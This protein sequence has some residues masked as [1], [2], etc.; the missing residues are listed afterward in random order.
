MIDDFTRLGITATDDL[1]LI[2]K[3]FRLEYR[4]PPPVEH[5][6]PRA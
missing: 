6:N 1:T 5:Q 4:D 2:K 3:A